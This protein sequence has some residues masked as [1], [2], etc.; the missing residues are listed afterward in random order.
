MRLGAENDGWRVVRTALSHE[1]IGGPR[2]ARAMLVTQRLWQIA[3]ERQW[4]QRD[5]VRSRFAHA[6]ASCEAARLLVYQAIDARIDGRSEDREVSLARVAIV[7]AE[8]CV[9]ELVLSLYEDESLDRGSMG[10]AQ[11]K[12]SMIAGLGGGSVEVQLNMIARALL[13]S[14]AS[15]R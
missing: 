12:T 14:E 4:C 8:R 15:P 1:R 11:L 9:A 2:Y 6:E 7:R 3:R 5:G 10:N 13:G